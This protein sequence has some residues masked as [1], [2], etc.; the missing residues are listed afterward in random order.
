MLNECQ[1]NYR[2]IT[3]RHNRVA[4]VVREVVVK[5]LG[6]DLRYDIHENTT[7]EQEGLPDEVRALKPD[8]A[9]KGKSEDSECWRSWN[10]RASTDRFPM[11]RTRS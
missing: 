1:P 10:S 3:A 11:T 9:S 8:M 5:F 2:L 4:K 7:I 6:G